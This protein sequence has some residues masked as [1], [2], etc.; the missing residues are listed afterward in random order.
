MRFGSEIL[1]LNLQL[2]YQTI[3]NLKCFEE[4]DYKNIDGIDPFSLMVKASAAIKQDTKIFA[5]KDIFFGLI[6]NPPN[7]QNQREGTNLLWFDYYKNSAGK[8][9]ISGKTTLPDILELV[10]EEVADDLIFNLNLF[11]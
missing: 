3:K 1:K 4:I 8:I 11:G 6:L 5:L 7:Y 2:D 10:N 9:V